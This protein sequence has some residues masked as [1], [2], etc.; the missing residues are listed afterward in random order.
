MKPYINILFCIFPQKY[1]VFVIF[2]YIFFSV[3]KACVTQNDDI[4]V[5]C[6]EK[7]VLRNVLKN[8]H[9]TRGDVLQ[10]NPSN[11][12]YRFAPYKQFLWFVFKRLGNE[13]RHIISL[14]VI[15]MMREKFPQEDGIYIPLKCGKD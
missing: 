10:Q 2:F 4:R 14:C 11:R 12:L 8:I 15:W 3:G 1:F 5:L 13:N 9:E 7:I 6:L